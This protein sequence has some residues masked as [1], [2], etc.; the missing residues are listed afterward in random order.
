MKKFCLFFILFLIFP[1]TMLGCNYGTNTNTISKT[2]NSNTNIFSVITQD[3]TNVTSTLRALDILYYE[4]YA[5][6]EL[7]PIVGYSTYQNQLNNYGINNDANSISNDLPA[8]TYRYNNNITYSYVP[9][10][11]LDTSALDTSFLQ[12][13]MQSLQDLFLITNDITAGNE[14]L[15]NQIYNIINE[16]LNV[17]NNAG[18]TTLST[19]TLSAEQYS[20]FNECSI[21]IN[22]VLTNIKNSSGFIDTELS[23][24]TTLRQNYYKN[25]E[26]LNI[27]YITI[28]NIIDNRI[29]QLQNLQLLIERLNKQLLVV[30]TALTN[31]AGNNAINNNIINNNYNNQNIVNN[32]TNNTLN[33]NSMVNNNKALNNNLNN[34]NNG[35][36]NNLNNNLNNSNNALNNNHY[37]NNTSNITNNNNLQNGTNI[38][39]DNIKNNLNNN[40]NNNCEN[41]ILV[42]DN[43]T[44][45][46]ILLDKNTELN[47]EPY[48]KNETSTL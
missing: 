2:K 42:N 8:S 15:N 10:Y 46:E 25:V 21:G 30:I 28:L 6:N 22:A 34:Y 18:L 3:M 45:K 40:L 19:I 24:L 35:N 38:N 7:N 47:Y 36:V 4:D 14:I 17:K 20:I 44:E 37:N 27:K 5:I 32:G 48:Y 41:N 39:N 43:L 23:S 11:I 26:A 16:A 29:V 13:Y 31:N 9:K 1:L 12:A 33:N